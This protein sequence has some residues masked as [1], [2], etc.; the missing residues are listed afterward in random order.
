LHNESKQKG[1][2][3]ENLPMGTFTIKIIKQ[4]ELFMSQLRKMRRIRAKLLNK[5]K[6]NLSDMENILLKSPVLVMVKMATL[7]KAGIKI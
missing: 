1:R 2:E 3:E 7:K 6:M 4:G 5:K